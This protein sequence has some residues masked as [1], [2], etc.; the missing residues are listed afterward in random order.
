VV[1]GKVKA[2]DVVK[3]SSARISQGQSVTIGTSNGVVVD[4]G[5]AVMSDIEAPISS[6]S[7]LKLGL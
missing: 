4:N 7:G 1:R 2:P 3:L 5:R 6:T